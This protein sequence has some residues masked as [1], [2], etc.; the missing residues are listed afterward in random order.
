MIRSICESQL[1]NIVRRSVRRL[2]RL[3]SRRT[4][5]DA[6]VG[7]ILS[8][9]VS[10]AAPMPPAVQRSRTWRPD[11]RRWYSSSSL[12]RVG[13]TKIPRGT[14]SLRFF[15]APFVAYARQKLDVD[16]IS[17]RFGQRSL[18]FSQMR[19]SFA[20]ET[21]AGSQKSFR[22]RIE[23]CR[24]GRGSEKGIFFEN[25]VGRK[26]GTGV[27]GAPGFA[28]ADLSAGQ[29]VGVATKPRSISWS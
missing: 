7:V 16:N 6:D 15:R 26:Q 24:H 11:D 3:C 2:A 5:A 14:P 10:L 18:T 20:S 19:I 17:R 23:Q 27:H 9:A 4:G 13:E 29:H 28:A 21:V 1:A 22:A 25:S 8:S 12:E